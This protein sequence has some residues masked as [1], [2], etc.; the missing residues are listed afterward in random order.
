MSAQQQQHVSSMVTDAQATDMTLVVQEVVQEVVTNVFGAASGAD[1]CDDQAK[2]HR[3][4][5][6]GAT[7]PTWVH[8]ERQDVEK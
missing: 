4:S 6:N 3:S 1:S 7:V 8:T 5:A 2:A